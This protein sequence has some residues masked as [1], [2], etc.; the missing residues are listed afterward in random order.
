MMK[1]SLLV[2]G[3][4]MTF[5][6]GGCASNAGLETSVESL[7]SKVAQMTSEMNVLRSEHDSLA[8]NTQAADDKAEAAASEAMRAHDRID[9]IV[10]SYQK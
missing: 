3:L 5:L 4:A 1:K 2:A 7:T 9:N 6:L 10:S 8:A